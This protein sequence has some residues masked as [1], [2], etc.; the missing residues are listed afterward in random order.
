[1]GER[2]VTSDIPPCIEKIQSN[3]DEYK[4][5][6][7]I[8]LKYY[9]TYNSSVLRVIL[10]MLKGIGINVQL[11][12]IS[13]PFSCSEVDFCTEEMKA[14]CPLRKSW[15]TILM[16]PKELYKF[17]TA[18]GYTRVI[19]VFGDKRFS[20]DIK[21]DKL[22]Q[23][24]REAMATHFDIYPDID[25]RRKSDR[26]L[27]SNLVNYW[28]THAKKIHEDD[29][30]EDTEEKRIREI[31]LNY[32]KSLRPTTRKDLIFY[33]NFCLYD[34]KTGLAY[35]L[36]DSILNEIKNQ[37]GE[38]ITAD[39]LTRILRGFAKPVRKMINYQRYTFYEFEPNEELL[40]QSIEDGL[41]GP[42]SGESESEKLEVIFGGPSE[43]HE[44]SLRGSGNG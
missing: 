2:K 34:E 24:I 9:Y 23:Q 10:P 5:R 43:H 26:A 35:C 30:E 31:V 16:H 25:M 41:I 18:D 40:K 14:S 17:E 32:L 13:E 4:D 20:I 33:E 12:H 42:K 37:T 15:Y 28:L 39:K 7:D 22:T 8:L 27:I 11:N 29:Y 38:R 1:V 36:R 6:I 21:A 19:L 44:D 3:F